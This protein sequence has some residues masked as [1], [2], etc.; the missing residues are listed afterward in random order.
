MASRIVAQL[1][2]AGATTLLR[3]G[4]QAF[5]K[6]LQNAQQSGVAQETVKAATRNASMTV[7]EAQ[8]ILGVG[9][10]APW[11]EVLKRY[12]HLF[13]VNEKHG[14]FYL[15][16]KVFRAWEAL[17]EEYTRRG[18]KPPGAEEDT[19][20]Q[21]PTGSIGSGGA[22]AGQQQQPEQQQQQQEQQGSGRRR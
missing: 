10:H 6:A 13:D 3:A 18:L 17:D 22:G 14:S 16:S 1:L 15:Q 12:R 11:A 4:S 19:A 21:G 20:Q 7:Q 9:E 8:M 5:A 2:V